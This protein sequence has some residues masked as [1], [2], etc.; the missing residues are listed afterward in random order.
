MVLRHTRKFGKGLVNLVIGAAVLGATLAGLGGCSK[1]ITDRDV[2]PITLVEVR[3]IVESPRPGHVLLIDPRSPASFAAGHLP[4][5]R[6]LQ[7]AEVRSERGTDPAMER[8]GELVVYGDDPGTASAV[9]MT[10]RLMMTGYKNV[11]MYMGGLSEWKR[12]G[13][14][15]EEGG[16]G[17]SR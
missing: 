10:K 3:A 7:L 14:R 6:N 15:V 13:L 16:G 2:V 1:Q 4:G 9:A 11:R 5:A 8:Y 12:A 17:E